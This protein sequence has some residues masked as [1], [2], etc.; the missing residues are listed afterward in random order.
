MAQQWPNDGPTMA[1]RWP[2]NGPTMAQRWRNDGATMAQQ[3]PNDGATSDDKSVFGVFCMWRCRLCDIVM[4]IRDADYMKTSHGI[5][6]R[7]TL[8]PEKSVVKVI[9]PLTPRFRSLRNPTTPPPLRRL[10]YLSRGSQAESWIHDVRHRS[11]VYMQYLQHVKEL[12]NEDVVVLFWVPWA[13]SASVSWE[14][15][16][17][18]SSPV[19]I[20]L[21]LCSEWL[22]SSPVQAGWTSPTVNKQGWNYTILFYVKFPPGIYNCYIQHTRCHEMLSMSLLS[23]LQFRCYFKL[24]NQKLK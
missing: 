3:W 9:D 24:H 12:S 1:Q 22:R 20:R 23:M 13:V 8:M 19:R 10:S 7:C 18:T 6:F 2:N 15:D 11:E 4:T 16:T 17:S 21:L 14:D 5:W